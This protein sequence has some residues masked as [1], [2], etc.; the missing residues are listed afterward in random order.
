MKKL[1][2]PSHLV[3]AILFI[4]Y[5][6]FIAIS[7]P[8]VF[9]SLSTLYDILKSAAVYGILALGFL[10]IIISGGIDMSFSSIAAVS[11][12]LTTIIL[13]KFGLGD[14]SLIV[15]YMTAIV[16][17]LILGIGNGYLVSLLKVPVIVTTLGT[18]A[19]LSGFLLFFVGSKVI[20]NIPRA[21]SSFSR[22]GLWAVADGGRNSSFH[23][24]I[25]IW[26]FLSIVMFIFLKYTIVGR[27]IY[28]LGGN[29]EIFERSGASRRKTEIT[30]FAI[31]G[32]FSAI[33]G[34]T[35]ASLNR[36]VTP[37]MFVGEELDIVAMVILGGA[38][39]TGGKGS[40][41]ATILGVLFIN[42]IRNSL[43]LIN[44]ASIWQVF[45]IGVVLFI[46]IV[47]PLLFEKIQSNK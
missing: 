37:N 12:Y 27:N 18:Q 13:I 20:F 1:S 6:S 23:P 25:F 32:V 28:A 10:P 46:G 5:S 40:I 34:V 43:I 8:K 19:M 42:L 38:S 15:I 29:A 3:L 39:I 17:G 16:I 2:L 11:T 14:A 26:I 45:V 31:S 22:L 35:F 9:F 33:A 7:N 30:I 47:L 4:A 21:L 41:V 36:I 24:A 44:V